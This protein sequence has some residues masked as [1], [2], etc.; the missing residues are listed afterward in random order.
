ML[1]KSTTF[2]YCILL[3]KQFLF[4]YYVAQITRLILV[5]GVDKMIFCR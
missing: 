4:I 5:Y 3:F 1:N 2:D